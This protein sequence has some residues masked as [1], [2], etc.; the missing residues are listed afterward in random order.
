MR[1]FALFLSGVIFCFSSVSPALPQNFELVD[2]T[3]FRVCA[4]P[5]NMPFSNQAEEGFENRIAALLAAKLDIPVNY[6]WF[7]QATGFVRNTLRQNKCDVIMGY[8]QGHELVY[9]TNHYYRSA[10]VLI[11]PKGGELGGVI[12]LGDSR[13][14][15]KKIGVIAGTPPATV[16]VLHGLIE[17]VA[18]YPLL[19]D[20]RFNSPAEKMLHDLEVGDIDAAILWGPIGGYYAKQLQDAVRVVPLIHEKVGPRMIYRI[21]LGVRP[22]EIRWKRFLD[23]LLRRN[24]GEINAILLDYGIPLL[25]ER[26]NL[27]TR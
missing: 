19:V 12:D 22:G 11:T 27:I 9:N 25:D 15:G 8:A 4:D 6:T 21:T 26:D 10:Y 1:F 24:R 18:G 7:P 20:R 2:R 5:A 16:M 17:D 13:L 3:I 14:R 23:R